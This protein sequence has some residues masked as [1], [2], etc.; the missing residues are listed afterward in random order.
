MTRRLEYSHPTQFVE[1]TCTYNSLYM[2]VR[3]ILQET[4]VPSQS[5]FLQ[6]EETSLP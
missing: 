6:L 2:T 3:N 1:L 4:Y 5:R